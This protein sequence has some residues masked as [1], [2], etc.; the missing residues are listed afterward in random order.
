MKVEPLTPIIGAEVS[1]LNLC[2]LTDHQFEGLR[3]AFTEHSVLFFRDQDAMT[4]ADQVAFARR[5]GP[6][7]THPAAP[8]LADAEYALERLGARAC[9]RERTAHCPLGESC[10][11]R[12]STQNDP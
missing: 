9:R 8:T 11:A 5:F 10:P 3:D 12:E 2:R 1:G 6:L 7:H 4:P